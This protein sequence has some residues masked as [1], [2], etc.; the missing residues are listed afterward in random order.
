[1]AGRLTEPYYYAQV[2]GT[3]VDPNRS[4]GVQAK[5]CG[6]TDEWAD[7]DQ[8][9]VYPRLGYGMQK[10]P[11]R[12]EWLLVS[13]SHGD[14]NEGLY[15]GVSQTTKFLPDEY[16]LGYPDVAVM[17]MGEEGYLYTHNRVSHTSFIRNPG[18]NSEIA[19]NE[20]GEVIVTSGDSSDEAGR[21]SLPVLT[22]GTID[23]FTC[24]PV[25]SP[26]TAARAGSE[27][28]SVAHISKKTIDA[29]R[30][31]VSVE[32]PA[33]PAQEPEVDG[34]DM[35]DIEG[36]S[37]KY[38]IPFIESPAVKRR[39]GKIAK[40][41]VIGCTGTML[42]SEALTTY[43]RDDAKLCVHFLVGLGDGDADVLINV[44]DAEHAKNLG[45]C[46]IA[47]IVDDTTYGSRINV[48]MGDK[49]N[50]DSVSVEFYG[51]GELNDYQKSKLAD[52]ANHVKKQFMLETIPV[53]ANAE[54]AQYLDALKQYEGD[55]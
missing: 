1:M 39:T 33:N 16:V 51:N 22:E 47:E 18:N 43:T 23:I 4:G 11:T 49:L 15:C 28:M 8:P 30:G 52:I 48:S 26:D 10:V 7:E 27:Y 36:V 2:T 46:E 42:Y 6:I 50:V 14:I 44:G 19:W 38:S 55:M 12:G 40:R 31:N 9:W 35:R 34:L 32:L 29:I 21:P 3:S 20:T 25:G 5:I 53:V 37:S 54:Q 17:N 41:I 13:F 45:F 24:M